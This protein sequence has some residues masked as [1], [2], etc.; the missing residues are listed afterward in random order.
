MGAPNFPRDGCP[1]VF[2][3]FKGGF[4]Q[5]APFSHLLYGIF[6]L[7]LFLLCLLVQKKKKHYGI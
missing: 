6:F 4:F 7:L 3:G 5:K 1:K 2:G